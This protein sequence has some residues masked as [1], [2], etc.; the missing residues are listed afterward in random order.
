MDGRFELHPELFG[1]CWALRDALSERGFD[2]L[3]HYSSVD[4]VHEEYG[5][6]VCGIHDRADA[7]AILTLLVE[8]YP[9]WRPG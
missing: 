5:L 7:R 4:P 2:W 3:S 8:R 6:E 1:E 9:G